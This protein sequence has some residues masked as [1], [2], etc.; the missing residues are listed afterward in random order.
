MKLVE[1]YLDQERYNPRLKATIPG[2]WIAVYDNDQEEYICPDYQASNAD[3]AKEYLL[4][5][6]GNRI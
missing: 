5:M 6:L 2:A 3:Q 4:S 1:I